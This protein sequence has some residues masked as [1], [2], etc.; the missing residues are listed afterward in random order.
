MTHTSLGRERQQPSSW[1]QRVCERNSS[2]QL[3][4][5]SWSGVNGRT[6]LA[7][8]PSALL[9]CLVVATDSP[10]IYMRK[11]T[12]ANIT[13]SLSTMCKIYQ[14]FCHW[15]TWEMLGRSNSLFL[16]RSRISSM[17]DSC[18]FVSFLACFSK[19]QYSLLSSACL[20]I[21][22]SGGGRGRDVGSPWNTYNYGT[23]GCF[24]NL[25]QN[26]R[27]SFF[28]SGGGRQDYYSPIL[29]PHPKHLFQKFTSSLT[30]LAQCIF[31]GSWACTL[32]PLVLQ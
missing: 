28:A 31:L 20:Q 32:K 1:R 21:W 10:L 29:I 22:E 25:F 2:K 13:E 5:E 19:S 7:G 3:E 23:S 15:N 17:D 4:R 27:S 12:I 11:K 18:F 30:G 16:H 14:T 26:T 8:K 6:A 24:P 9:V